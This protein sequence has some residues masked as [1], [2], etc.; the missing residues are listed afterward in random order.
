MGAGSLSTGSQQNIHDLKFQ[1]EVNVG[2]V[3][4]ER[5][6][7]VELIGR[8]GCG[9]VFLANDRNLGRSVAI[10]VLSGEGLREK[11]TLEKFEQEGQ[12]LR[13]LHAPN[14]V[15][16]YDY[17]ETP[18]HLPYIVMEF[19]RGTPLKTVLK[20]EGRLT[21]KRTVSILSQVFASLAEAH[22]YGFVHRDLK[23][24]N[25]MLCNRLGFDEDYVKVLDFGIAKVMKKGENIDVNKD[26]IEDMA[27]TPKY[28]PPEQF[29]NEPLTPA[30]D[31]YSIGC[32][33]YEMI[34]GYSPF[35]GDTLHVTV[36]KHLFMI[37]PSLNAEVDPYP[38]VAATVF[39]LLE[40]DPANRFASAQQVIDVLEHWK[41]PKLIP[42]LQ[43]CRVHGDDS[44]S[45]TFY[46][47][48]CAE[49]VPLEINPEI[50]SKIADLPK[51]DPATATPQAIPIKSVSVEIAQPTAKHKNPMPFIYAVAGVILVILITL[52]VLV[53]VKQNQKTEHEQD[54]PVAEEKQAEPEPTAPKIEITRTMLDDSSFALSAGAISGIAYG[55]MTPS[56]LVKPVNIAFPSPNIVYKDAPSKKKKN[57]K[58]EKFEYQLDV[59]P[60]HANVYPQYASVDCQNGRCTVKTLS[61]QDYSS[62][63]VV[64]NGY[65]PIHLLITRRV[66]TV[67][68]QLDRE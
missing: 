21:I 45:N 65:K 42:E 3:L 35:E 59:T 60:A 1:D 17:G 22:S 49:T 25:I 57:Q 54:D 62:I 32:I 63:L 18:K 5:Y 61:D 48:E 24:G 33:A 64:A 20:N 29:K 51:V 50:M 23:P 52:I 55:F 41:E 30:A 8:G 53:F 19:V 15:F 39:K 34:S 37:P 10:K 4:D 67:S 38:N 58:I 56:D 16:F 46:E 9:L 12:I 68:I 40:K 6:E 44:Q 26:H 7:L 43:G 2:D 11:G 14:T 66:S 28:M 36:A 47:T 31:L 13:R 27:G